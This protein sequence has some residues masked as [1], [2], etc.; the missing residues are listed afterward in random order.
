MSNIL[1]NGAKVSFVPLIRDWLG[2]DKIERFT[3]TERNS[4]RSVANDETGWDRIK[5]MFEVK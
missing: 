1:R 2:F 5:R 3:P 4:D